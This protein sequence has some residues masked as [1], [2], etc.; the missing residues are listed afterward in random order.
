[1][2]KGSAAP[3][4]DHHLKFFLSREETK[5]SGTFEL[6][7]KGIG[8][9]TKDPTETDAS[10]SFELIRAPFPNFHLTITGKFPKYENIRLKID[11]EKNGQV[12]N[13][14]V[15]G[16]LGESQVVFVSNIENSADKKTLD[17]S[18]NLNNDPQRKLTLV[19]A[20]AAKVNEI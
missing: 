5:I 18:L 10:L 3:S 14:T 12:R 11:H 7:D 4:K 17:W 15:D 16:K 6:H 19:Y 9:L 20:D 2:A 13:T 8:H 1:M